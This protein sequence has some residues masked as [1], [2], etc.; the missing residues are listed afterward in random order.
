M[1]N[2]PCR[3]CQPTFLRMNFVDFSS[4]VK[5]HNTTEQ[6]VIQISYLI[7]SPVAAPAQSVHENCKFIVAVVYGSQIWSGSSL[8]PEWKL[9]IVQTNIRY[10][11]DQNQIYR[12]E[13]QGV[14]KF[15]P[16]LSRGIALSHVASI[17]YAFNH[18]IHTLR[19]F[20]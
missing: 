3:L 11:L 1:H 9:D 20:F 10:T 14:P 2:L 13:L 16:Q 17:T 7:L 15:L 6:N 18:V 8:D 19:E 5:G 12:S 4:T